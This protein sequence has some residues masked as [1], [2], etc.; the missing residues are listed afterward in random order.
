[1]N[2]S[3]VE[4]SLLEESADSSVD[5]ATNP[6]SAPTQSG[7]AFEAMNLR[8]G[9]RL[10]VQPPARVSLE[11]CPVRLIGYLQD[12]SLLITAPA[13]PNSVRLQMMEGDSLVMRY[14]SGQNAFG[15]AC[16]VQRVCKLPY[17]YLHIGFPAK[18]QGTVIRKAARVRTKVIARI[19][20][21]KDAHAAHTGV[22]SNLS[23]NGALLDARRSVAETGDVIKLV[24]KLKLH[25]IQTEL[26]LSAVVRTCFDD[27]NLKQ[28]GASLSHFG[29]QFTDLSPNDQM[30][31]Q[32]MVYQHMIEQPQSVI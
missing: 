28:S 27:E 13:T 6:E 17:N 5:Q 30:L 23:A 26:S 32:S 31:L 3:T 7:F 8:V 2:S 25:G 21:E 14:F 18:I 4:Q 16:D 1:M 12:M 22:I 19:S 20:T 15:F 10:Q 9:D 29:L 24:F 11:R